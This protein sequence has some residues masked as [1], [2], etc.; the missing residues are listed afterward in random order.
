[1]TFAE[2]VQ[3]ATAELEARQAFISRFNPGG[4]LEWIE[5][6]GHRANLIGPPAMVASYVVNLA[7]HDRA[8][9]GPIPKSWNECAPAT[10]RAL[11]LVALE[12]ADKREAADFA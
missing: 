6:P 8:E 3:L 12:H 9:V 11:A 10:L 5:D 1:M 7:G 2:I 4:D